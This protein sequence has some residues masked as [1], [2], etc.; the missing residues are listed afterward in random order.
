[1][2]FTT[3]Y[4][5]TNPN[6][7]G[8]DLSQIFPPYEISS[9]SVANSSADITGTIT[10]TNNKTSTI[11]YHVFA[12]Y[13]YGLPGGSSGTYNWQNASNGASS[14]LIFTKTSAN[15]QFGFTKGTGNTW[16]GSISFLV[17]YP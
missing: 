8:L 9:F 7:S 5:V 14:I 6:Y 16:N 12:T 17:I 11:D 3:N 15:F 13:F 10:L 2:S 4:K 1:M